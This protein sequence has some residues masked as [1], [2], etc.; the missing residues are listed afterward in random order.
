MASRRR[1]GRKVPLKANVDAAIAKVAK[2]GFEV[3]HV[4]VVQ[5]TGTKV[6]MDPV[7]DVY[8]HEAAIQT[9]FW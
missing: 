1:G 5:R 4:I 6:E 8:Y 3:D 9:A 2:D 7:R